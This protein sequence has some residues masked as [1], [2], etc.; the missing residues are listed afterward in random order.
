M[1]GKKLINEN[2]ISSDSQTALKATINYL[3]NINRLDVLWVPAHSDIE[4]NE[5]ADEIAKN[6]A[7]STATEPEPKPM[8][9]IPLTHSKR[10]I[11][12]LRDEKFDS[13]TRLQKS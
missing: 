13:S 11:T 4:G 12:A 1:V 6:A 5:I 2:F 3:T 9:N 8:I 10:L 7:L